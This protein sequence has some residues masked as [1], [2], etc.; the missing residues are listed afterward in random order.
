[1][2]IIIKSLWRA[3]SHLIWRDCLFYCI[4]TGGR[5]GY[6]RR[7]VAP[8]NWW[9]ALNYMFVHVHCHFVL[10]CL[11]HNIYVRTHIHTYVC[12]CGVCLNLI[13]LIYLLRRFLFHILFYFILCGCHR[14]RSLNILFLWLFDL[15]IHNIMTWYKRCSLTI[16]HMQVRKLSLS[17]FWL[18]YRIRDSVD[19][20]HW[21]V[22]SFSVYIGR[23]RWHA[24]STNLNEDGDMI[25]LIWCLSAFPTRTHTT[26]YIKV[27]HRTF[28]FNRCGCS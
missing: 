17:F 9:Y 8:F 3:F 20:H 5:Y 14:C 1:M 12:V 24:K 23:K 16:H 10:D 26:Q 11:C 22:L 4:L 15:I 18:E 7:T 13:P 19:L 6:D 25:S 27:A 28:S 21:K 2:Y